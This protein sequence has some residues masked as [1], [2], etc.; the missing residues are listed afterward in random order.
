VTPLTPD[1]VSDRPAG[2]G[3]ARVQRLFITGGSGYLG[4][5][6]IQAAQGWEVYATYHTHPFTPPRGTAF[7]LNLQDEAATRAAL[8]ATR[9]D[10]ILHTACSNRSAEHIHAIVPA[11]RHLAH[12]AGTHNIR[13]IHVSSDTVFDGEHAPYSDD[14]P[15]DPVSEYG[16]AKAEAE[17]IVAGHCP[18]ALIVRPSLIWSL[19]PI[20]HQTRWLVEGIRN[21]ETITLFTDEFRN[22]VYLYDLVGALLELAARPEFT[23]RMNLGGPQALNRWDFGMKLLTALRIRAEPYVLQHRVKDSGLIRPR[24]LTL[25]SDRAVRELRTRLRS[26]D[27]VLSHA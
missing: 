2:G 18:S 19:D 22:P 17:A 7:A 8:L 13:L 3:D 15:T 25:I 21:Q 14:S 24:D 5:H 12:W 6:V 27:E 11:A 4:S 1:P 9:P 10:V 26:V 16:R 20:D 23:G